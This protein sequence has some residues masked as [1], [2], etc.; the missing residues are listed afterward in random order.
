MI[1]ETTSTATHKGLDPTKFYI[2]EPKTGIDAEDLLSAV[3]IKLLGTFPFFGKIA[4]NMAFVE[5]NQIPTTAVD[6]RGTF[7]FNRKWVNHFDEK[8]ALFEMGHEVMHLVQRL[9]SRKGQGINHGLWNLAADYLADTALIDAGLPQSTVSERMLT[10]ENQ[11][12]AR[13]HDTVPAMYRYLLQKAEENTECPACKQMLKDLKTMQKK[14]QKE[15]QE[16]NSKLNAQKENAPGEEKSEEEGNTSEGGVPDKSNADDG[17]GSGCGSPGELK[18]TCGNVRQCCAGSSTDVNGMDPAD[19]QK[20]TEVV[21]SAKVHA[22][23][24]GKMPAGLSDYIDSL[25]ESKVRWQDH[26]KSAATRLFGRDR[27]TYKRTNRRGPAMQMRLPGHTP[28][29]KTAIGSI[30]TSASMSTEE[31]RQCVTEFSGI[32]KLC[33]C[34]KLWLILHDT[35]VYFSGWVEEADLTKLKMARGGTSHHEVFACLD[36]EHSNPYF[37]LPKEEEVTLAVMFTD[38][39]TSFPSNAPD[40][41]VI[42]GVPSNGCPGMSATVPFGK[43]VEVE[44]GED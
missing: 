29:G 20:W 1:S 35:R 22:E 18:H 44:V 30:D 19:V 33:G 17:K 15:E 11:A 31:V 23:G 8:D 21:I 2:D 36:K 32:M 41:E 13:K 12:L 24:K 27:Y 43:K 26:I 34:S 42:W 40:Y 14:Q 38:L 16:E 39:G 5:S 37:N 7:Y 9:W 28:D 10:P 4:L 25:T 6:A 3:R